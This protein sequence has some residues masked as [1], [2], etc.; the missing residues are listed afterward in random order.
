MAG[1]NSKAAYARKLLSL[2]DS[3]P[4]RRFCR[5]TVLV[6]SQKLDKL[7]ATRSLGICEMR[8]AKN[9]SCSA[10]DLSG[11]FCYRDEIMK[12]AVKTRKPLSRRNSCRT[13]PIGCTG[14]AR[15]LNEPVPPCD[16]AV[17]VGE[18]HFCTYADRHLFEQRTSAES[19]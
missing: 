9:G 5:T 16:F 7:K 19:R 8:G 1:E 11:C 4:F 10:V 17:P 2:D 15:C 13:L 18:L 6:V 14:L 3:D 12:E